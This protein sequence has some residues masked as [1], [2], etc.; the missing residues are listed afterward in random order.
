MKITSLNVNQLFGLGTR[1]EYPSNNPEKKE[2][3]WAELK[4][5][6]INLY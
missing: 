3:K 5:Q 4:N 2:K 1:N 6:I